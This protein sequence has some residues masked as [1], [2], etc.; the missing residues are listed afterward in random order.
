PL[1]NRTEREKGWR[2]CVSWICLYAAGISLQPVP[3][4]QVSVTPA[5]GSAFRLMKAGNTLVVRLRKRPILRPLEGILQSGVQWLFVD[6]S[7]R[8]PLRHEKNALIEVSITS[9]DKIVKVLKQSVATCAP[10]FQ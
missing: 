4:Q 1:H 5:S 8:F 2:I 7:D 6:V 9:D 10:T 3:A